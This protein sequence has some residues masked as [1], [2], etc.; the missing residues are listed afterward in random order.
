MRTRLRV[1][2][3]RLNSL[4]RLVLNQPAAANCH[5]YFICRRRRIGRCFVLA[6]LQHAPC[7][8][9]ILNKKSIRWKKKM[10]RKEGK[11]WNQIRGGPKGGEPAADPRFSLHLFCPFRKPRCSLEIYPPPPRIHRLNLLIKTHVVVMSFTR[12]LR[13][14]LTHRHLKDRSISDCLIN[15][16]ISDYGFFF[17]VSCFWVKC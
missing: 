17:N 4:L 7:R 8:Q 13:N 14:L 11:E 15:F 5:R 10:K 16:L 2:P 9:K 12:E 1:C 3:S 6:S